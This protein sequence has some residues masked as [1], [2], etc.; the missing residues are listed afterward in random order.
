MTTIINADT[1]TGG[2]VITGDGSGILA[3]QSGGV[4]KL[5]VNSSGVT[6]A[7][8]LPVASGGTGG[9]ATPTA[10]GIV[11][12]TGSAQ[13]VTAAGTTGQ[14]LTSAGSGT[15]TW[16][17]PATGA[18]TLI[19]TLTPTSGATALS[20]LST[21]SSSYDNYLVICSGLQASTGGGDNLVIQFAN[22]GTLDTGVRYGAS[23][24][25]N[26]PNLSTSQSSAAISGII[27]DTAN[28]GSGNVQIQIMNVNSTAYVKTAYAI[29]QSRTSTSYASYA[30]Q[31]VYSNTSATVSGFSISFGSG[32]GFA[33]VGK[34][35]VYGY[36]NS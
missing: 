27:S 3:L 13:A 19:A 15:P 20:F 14:V 5:T 32:G 33:A 26:N 11:Y 34:V 23:S 7:A 22:S 10:G 18:L 2:A 30:Y 25:T 8:P 28:A 9:S 12:G 31:I 16:S 36:A 1:S 29:S 17:T 21:F 24:F 6:L 35:R 4:T